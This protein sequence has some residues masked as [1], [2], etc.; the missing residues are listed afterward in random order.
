[1]SDNN[2]LARVGW[3]TNPEYSSFEDE[4]WIITLVEFTAKLLQQDRVRIIGVCFG[5]QILG[6]AMGVK[7]GRNDDGWEV[8]VNDVDL[9]EKGKQ[10][11]GKETLASDFLWLSF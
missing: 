8:A 10:L 4:A 1:M 2:T 6:R 11:F 7:L 3:L 9:S 5:H